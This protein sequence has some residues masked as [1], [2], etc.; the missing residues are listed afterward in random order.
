MAFVRS[1]LEVFDLDSLTDTAVAPRQGESQV[2]PGER[3]GR[4]GGHQ[5]GAECH[6]RR[7]EVAGGR[8][9]SP[10]SSHRSV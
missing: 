4:G 8:S 5:Q 10:C 6:W 7:S 2:Q 1:S 3:Q 9:G